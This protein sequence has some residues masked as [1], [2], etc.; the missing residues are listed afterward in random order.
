LSKHHIML[1]LARKNR[2][3]WINNVGNRNPTISRHDLTRMVLKVFE[4]AAGVKKVSPNIYAFSPLLI[5]FHGS[6]AARLL[7]RLLLRWS[8]GSVCRKLG[9]KN[10]INWSFAPSAGDIIGNLGEKFVIYHCVD[11]FSEFRGTDKA[12]IAAIEQRL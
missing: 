6:G 11:E 8:I 10:P 7:N 5:P 1:R 2:I 12:A 3:L 9:F 4:F